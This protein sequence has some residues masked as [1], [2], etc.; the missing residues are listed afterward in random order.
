MGSSR[1][2]HG[3]RSGGSGAGPGGYGSGGRPGGGGYGYGPGG[4]RNNANNNN[5]NNNSSNNNSGGNGHPYGGI[6]DAPK[7][8]PEFDAMSNREISELLNDR[9]KFDHL[10]QTHP[11]TAAVEA[12]L[13]PLRTQI[14]TSTAT[15]TTPSTTVCDAD[16][17]DEEQLRADVVRLR[18]V[19]SDWVGKNTES[20]L[21]NRL[22]ALIEEDEKLSLRIVDEWRSE[23]L[24]YS[25]FIIKFIE[26]RTRIAERKLKLDSFRE[27]MQRAK[28]N[29]R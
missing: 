1:H 11:H 8:Y 25:E 3:G 19:R 24:A 17:V 27:K 13:A 18:K 6:P 20:H 26:V 23:Q 21:E 2:G 28:M 7:H 9:A 22:V 29:A 16:V 5:N 4:G 12:A 10:I 15:N 14:I